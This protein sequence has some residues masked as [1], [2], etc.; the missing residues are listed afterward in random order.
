MQF[1]IWV[2]QHVRL[3]HLLKMSNGEACARSR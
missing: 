2:G 1:P 3:L